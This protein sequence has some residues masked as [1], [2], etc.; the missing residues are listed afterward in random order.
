MGSP[1]LLRNL[2]DGSAIAHEFFLNYAD[3]ATEDMSMDI[4]WEIIVRDVPRSIQ[5][6]YAEL[7]Y[8]V[9]EYNLY[10]MEL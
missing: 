9:F 1:S 6:V 7:Y 8:E 4:Y 10:L 3:D 5:K 2:Q